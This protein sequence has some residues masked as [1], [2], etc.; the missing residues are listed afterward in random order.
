LAFALPE[1]DFLLSYNKIRS[2]IVAG[3]GFNVTEIEALHPA[4]LPVCFAKVLHLHLPSLAPVGG[5]REAERFTL[6]RR[7][8]RVSQASKVD[9]RIESVGLAPVMSQCFGPHI[10]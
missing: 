6:A 10:D 7:S 3:Y 4:T 2:K 5:R 9:A 1:D 8:Q